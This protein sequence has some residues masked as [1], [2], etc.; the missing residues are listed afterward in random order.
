VNAFLRHATS[1]NSSASHGLWC[2]S[3][4]EQLLAEG[5][6]EGRG[7]SGTYLSEG[8]GRTALIKEIRSATLKLSCYGSAAADAVEA[9]D[10]PHRRASPVRYDF[11]Y[12]RSAIESFPP[13]MWRRILLRYARQ[14]RVRS[15]VGLNGVCRYLP[16]ANS[17]VDCFFGKRPRPGSRAGSPR[18]N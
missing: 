9:V 2:C 7:G 3:A 6:A 18:M 8:L 17:K 13:E 11:A 10:S 16:A 4:Y 14:A 12:G 15:S 1:P 5:F